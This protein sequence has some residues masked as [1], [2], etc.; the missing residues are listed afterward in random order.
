MPSG[1][2]TPIPSPQPGFE[3]STPGSDGKRALKQ[4]SLHWFPRLWLA[5]LENT[6]RQTEPIVTGILTLYT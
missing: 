1:G 2:F 4:G 5:L 3:G 6:K